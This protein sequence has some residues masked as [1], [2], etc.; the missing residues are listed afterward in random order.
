MKII[1]NGQ[2]ELLETKQVS[3]TEL[4]RL[5]NIQMPEMVSVELN[6]EILEREVFGSTLLKEGDRIEFLYFMGGGALHPEDEWEFET[7]AVHAGF[8]QDKETGATSL[9]IYQTAAF[10]YQSAE[11]LSDVFAGKKFGYVYSRIANPTITAFENRINSLENGRAAVATSSGM[12]AIATIILSL[13]RQGE[14]IIS[15]KSIFG[16]TYLLYREILERNGITVKYVEAPD[17]DAYRAAV[18]DKTRLIFLETIGNPKL[19]VANIAGVAKV[20][21]NACVPLVC[22]STLTTPYLFQAKKFGVDV[23]V[24]STTKYISGG[25]GAIGGVLIDL[26][27][28]NWRECRTPEIRKLSKKFGEFAFIVRCRKGILQNLGACL[29][30]FNAYLQNLGLE[31]MALRMERHCSNA[32]KLAR[33]L[34]E[35][36]K[37]A[38]TTY[39]GLPESPYYRIAR[40]Q[41]SNG[42]GGLLTF[43]LSSRKDCFRFINSLKLAKNAVNLGDNKT[44][45]I[46]PASTIFQDCSPDETEAAGVNDSLIRVSVGIENTKDIITDFDQALRSV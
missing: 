40:K 38:R 5:K 10:A 37:V 39:P 17:V 12:A 44:L 23:C 22:D 6:E 21:K 46:H 35:N 9:P 18:T 11:E 7:R 28:F 4:L 13:A 20:A 30:P 31:T 29:A 2:E 45:V 41:F 8:S 26:G 32:L 43:Q 3:I 36:K 14:E 27:N 25:G 33:F 1:I 19:D 15:S 42:F 34:K 16:G 24:H